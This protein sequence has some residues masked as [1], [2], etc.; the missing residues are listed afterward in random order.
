MAVNRF[1]RL[2]PQQYVSS[3]IEMPFEEILKVGA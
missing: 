2:N 3:Y 1:T